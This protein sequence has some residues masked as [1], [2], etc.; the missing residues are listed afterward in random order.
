MEVLRVQDA[1]IGSKIQVKTTKLLRLGINEGKEVML[2]N[3]INQAD[4]FTYVGGII[5]VESGCGED[6]RN[7]I[8]KGQFFFMVK[9][10]CGRK[11]R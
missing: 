4:S 3:K 6:V 7:R 8:N 11:T 5:S 1:R 10:K 2:C 9:K